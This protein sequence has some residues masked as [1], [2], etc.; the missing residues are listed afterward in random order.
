MDSALSVNDS[1]AYLWFTESRFRLRA[2]E[3]DRAREAFDRAVS[4]DPA[5]VARLTETPR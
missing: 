5:L 4:I 2:G 1:S 3:P